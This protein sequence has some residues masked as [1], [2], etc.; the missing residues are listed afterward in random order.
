MGCP[1]LRHREARSAR[2][3]DLHQLA[4]NL[5]EIAASPPHRCAVTRLLAMTV[6]GRHSE[7]SN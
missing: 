7:R 5:G 2:R 4:A 1:L 6:G 3:G